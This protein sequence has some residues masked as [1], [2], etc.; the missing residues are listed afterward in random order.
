MLLGGAGEPQIDTR[1]RVDL[2]FRVRCVALAAASDGGLGTTA[3]WQE[4]DRRGGDQRDHSY[5]NS[6]PKRRSTG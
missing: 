4:D 5:A 6:S 2:H 3:S 1:K